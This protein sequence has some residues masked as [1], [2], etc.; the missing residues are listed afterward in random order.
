MRLLAL[1]ALA[2]A[3][4]FTLSNT[5]KCFIEEVPRDT[6]IVAQW[7]AESDTA[8]ENI[9]DV[10]VKLS[11]Y[12]ADGTVIR[13]ERVADGTWEIVTAVGGDNKLCFRTDD[14]RFSMRRFGRG[15][16]NL[17]Y[18]SLFPFLSTQCPLE[19][20]SICPR[21]VF[22]LFHFAKAVLT[23]SAGSTCS[24]RLVLMPQTMPRS[25]RTRSFSVSKSASISL[26]SFVFVC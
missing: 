16:R 23:L 26:R 3:L 20:R 1:I 2:N 25:P 8:G 21:G 22:L 6:K 15:A 12:S 18:P 17:K 13:E 11:F 10:R 14:S 9:E 7:R 4:Y 24:W 5:D 19:P